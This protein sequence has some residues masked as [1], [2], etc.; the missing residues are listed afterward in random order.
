MVFAK[1]IRKALLSTD[2]ERKFKQL[3]WNAFLSVRLTT[4]RHLKEKIISEVSS[5]LNSV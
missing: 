4:I 5:I 3:V 1:K 2:I